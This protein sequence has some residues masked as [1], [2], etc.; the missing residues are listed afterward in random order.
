M[1]AMLGELVQLATSGSSDVRQIRAAARLMSLLEQ[2]PQRLPELFRYVPREAWPQPE[3]VLG[4][5]GAP[6]SGK[7][8]LTDALVAEFRRRDA[9]RRIGVIAVDPSSPFSGGAIL[10][11]RVRMMRHATDSRIFIRSLASRGHL[12]GL[13][14]GTRGILYIMGLIGC[15]TVLI[16]TVGVGQS[17]I[18][19]A[20][21][22]D[23]VT[24]VLAPGYGDAIQMLKA[25][26]LEAGDL[27]IINKADTEGAL[28]LYSALTSTLNLIPAD[29][30]APKNI[31]RIGRKRPLRRD[32]RL[33]SA[34]EGTGI[35]ELV[36]VLERHTIEEG[37]RWLAERE[38][39]LRDDVRRAVLEDARRRI[40]SVIDD[41][42]L[43]SILRGDAAVAD[44]SRQLLE[45]AADVSVNQ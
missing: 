28:Q 19:I 3:L 12:G 33:V 27:F 6:G 32:V 29:E 4:I 5:T 17:E 44:I 14:L 1:Q 9:D 30:T 39:S 21:V 45:A 11:D 23:L 18:E 43:D 42:H 10:G 16:E 36:D 40:G 7:S 37:A 24:V 20:G 2:E 8:T 25:G 15:K 26:L 34:M 41:E 22:A 13:S 35:P 31:S 38:T